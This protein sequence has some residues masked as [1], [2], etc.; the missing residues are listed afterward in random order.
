MSDTCIKC[1]R[2]S[3]LELS[4]DGKVKLCKRCSIER[5]ENYKAIRLPECAGIESNLEY[6]KSQIGNLI[7]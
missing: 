4:F 6:Y 7:I 3:N 5:F 1:N 2:Q